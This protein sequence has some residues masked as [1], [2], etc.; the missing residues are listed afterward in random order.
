M[1]G[2]DKGKY[3]WKGAYFFVRIYFDQPVVCSCAGDPLDAII[4]GNQLPYGYTG[5]VKVKGIM[6]FLDAGLVDDKLICTQ[7]IPGNL[8]EPQQ[9]S[10]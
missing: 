9:V 5:K 8:F 1:Q 7:L 3:Q 10:S 6:K 4:L 2:V